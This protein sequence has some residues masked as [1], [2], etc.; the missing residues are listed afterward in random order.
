MNQI[1]KI[2]F[3]AAAIALLSLS[4][5]AQEPEGKGYAELFYEADHQA[6]ESRLREAV[7]EDPK[8]AE[9]WYYL[10]LSQLMLGR[11]SFAEKSLRKAYGLGLQRG[12]IK[13]ACEVAKAD[14]G[15]CKEVKFFG[16]RPSR[17]TERPRD[18]NYSFHGI[19]RVLAV[20]GPDK[21]IRAVAI[22]PLRPGLD[23]NAV[24]AAKSL[25][26]KPATVRGRPVISTMVLE[27]SFYIY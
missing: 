24:E 8:D 10:G 17:Y 27:Y 7:E 2:L 6:T 21:K 19:V 3:I 16:K 13:T 5:A 4:I 12:V 26:F 1:R 22:K 9:A 23:K 25:K 11:D 20:F 15:E 18:D 14:K